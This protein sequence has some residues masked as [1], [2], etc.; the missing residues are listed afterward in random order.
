MSRGLQDEAVAAL[1]QV[2]ALDPGHASAHINLASAYIH[3]GQP[4][5]AINAYESFLALPGAPDPLR[6][7]VRGQLKLLRALPAR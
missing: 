5:A 6:K 2:L 3:L 7:K 1:Q 4:A